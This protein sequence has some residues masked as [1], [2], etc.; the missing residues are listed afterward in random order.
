MGLYRVKIVE[1]TTASQFIPDIGSACILDIRDDV[2]AGLRHR[3][4]MDNGELEEILL[5]QNLARSRGFEPL[6]TRFVV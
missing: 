5:A 6:T 4:R 3:Q 2:L 1:K